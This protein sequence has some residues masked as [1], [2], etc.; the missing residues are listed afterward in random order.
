V[1]PDGHAGMLLTELCVRDI[2][3][4]SEHVIGMKG[5][6]ALEAISLLLQIAAILTRM[7]DVIEKTLFKRSK[8]STD[9]HF[10]EQ[11]MPTKL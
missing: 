1:I 3:S 8:S 7:A 2:V 5:S 6:C 11:I 4:L 9:M 10:F